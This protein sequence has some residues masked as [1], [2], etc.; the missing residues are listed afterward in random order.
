MYTYIQCFIPLFNCI[1]TVYV[2]VYMGMCDVT[3]CIV[4]VNSDK[5]YVV[6]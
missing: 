2:S 6:L 5:T 3:S 4:N 1:F